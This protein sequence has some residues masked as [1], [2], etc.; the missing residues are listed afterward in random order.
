MRAPLD[1]IKKSLPLLC[2]VLLTAL[3]ACGEAAHKQVPGPQVSAS[4]NSDHSQSPPVTVEKPRLVPQSQIQDLRSRVGREI[5]RL[6]GK[7]ESSVMIMDV[8]TKQVL[9]GHRQTMEEIPASNMK[10][11][12]GAVVV[13]QLGLDHRLKTRFAMDGTMEAGV[14]SGDLVVIGGGDP[15]FSARFF[16]GDPT[17]PMEVLAE[18]LIDQGLTRID[19]RIL[20]DGRAFVG[21]RTG[22]AWP[23]DAVWKTYMVDV[24]PL[25]FNDNQTTFKLRTVAGKPRVRPFP[26]I[27]Y[28]KVK[29][30]LSLTNN[31]KSHSVDV[32][33]GNHSNDFSVLGRLWRKG[34][35]F[36]TKANVHN[37]SLYFVHA[38][39]RALRNKGVVVE[40]GVGAVESDF[41]VSSL[42]DL[43]VYTSKLERTLAPMLKY[44]QN[45]YAE[46]VLR[47]LGNELQGEGSF[48]G[49]TTALTAWLQERGILEE[50]TVIADGSGLSRKNK[51]SAQ[52]MVKALVEVAQEEEKRDQFCELLAQPKRPGT[53]NRRMNKLEG[54]VFAKTG[55][56]SGISALSGYVKIAPKRYVAFSVLCNH[57]QISRA[58]KAQDAICA[59]IAGLR[60]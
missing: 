49:G 37:G 53:L 58:R 35:G 27:G 25:V 38:L 41:D 59:A 54:R 2:A 40:G 26:D 56:M 29:N 11:I 10:L 20:A 44:S 15:T 9:F 17:R 5:S 14:L 13:D 46:L 55:T 3:V 21:P 39:H 34:A 50:G 23:K 7:V 52:Q 1:P 47:V 42:D 32:R 18:A 8:S 31:K 19:G 43:M 24:R 45:L 22:P 6:G 12:L 48:E 51:V 36:E 30:K 57:A 28:V 4:S 33:R 60:P 16:D